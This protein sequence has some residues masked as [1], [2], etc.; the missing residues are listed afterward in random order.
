M[1]SAHINTAQFK[2]ENGT[3][4][5]YDVKFEVMRGASLNKTVCWHVMSSGLVEWKKHFRGGTVKGQSYPD[6]YLEGTAGS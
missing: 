2:T 3:D 6:M 1:I 5:Y 4:R